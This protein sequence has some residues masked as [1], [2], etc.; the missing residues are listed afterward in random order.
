MRH[1]GGVAALALLATA[2]CSSSEEA[3]APAGGDD[4]KGFHVEN[5]FIRDP[6]G[7]ALI[8]R[9]M[10]LSGRHKY[11]PYFDFQEPPDYARI[12]DPWGM[13]MVRFLVTWAAIEPVEGVYDETYLDALERRMAWARDAGLFVVLDMHQDVY[14][15][16]FASGGGDG[17]PGWTCDNAA[18]ESFKPSATQWFL[19]YLTPEVTGCYDHFWTSKDLRAHYIEAWRRVAHRLKG[20]EGTVLGFDPMNE[21]YWGSYG[22]LQFEADRLQ[23]FY[24]D[25]TAAIRAEQPGWIAFVE[26]ASSRN[27]GIATGLT[28]F[29]FDNVNYSPHSYDRNAESGMGFDPSHRDAVLQNGAALAMEAKSLNASLWVGEYGGRADNPGIVD[30]MTA[31][32][33]AFAA[34]AGGT[35]YWAY[36]KGGY[37]VLAEDGSEKKDLMGALVRPWPERVAGDPEGYAFDAATSTFTLRFTPDASISAP[38]VIVV[39][40]RVYPNGYVVDCGG[41]TTKPQK[42]TV[43]LTQVP[44]GSVAVVTV[45]PK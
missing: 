16:G 35:S 44:A 36:D 13:N 24:E 21:P 23:P 7:R 31:E 22:I 17:A 32:Y 25:V 41:C 1:L 5:G 19:N 15:E 27:I 8:L 39:P 38:T 43:E 4:A 30:Y 3:I 42:G 18:Y 9:G 26:P 34:V 2:A 37:G 11:A 10:N 20:Y 45:K 6:Q 14:G 12:R 33:D 28:P 29:T 40:D